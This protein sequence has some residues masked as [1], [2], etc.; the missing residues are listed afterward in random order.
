MAHLMQQLAEYKGYCCVRSL[1]V[2]NRGKTNEEL[3]EIYGV[4]SRA[5]QEWRSKVRKGLCNC[6]QLP[7][8]EFPILD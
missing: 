3:A 4:S 2:Q 5:I 1:L 8:C 6:K 7:T